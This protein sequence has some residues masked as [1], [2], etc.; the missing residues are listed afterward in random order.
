MSMDIEVVDSAFCQPAVGVAVTLLREVDTA[1]QEQAAVRTDEDGRTP[2]LGQYLHRG[3]YRLVLSFDQYFASLGVDSFQSCIDI[4]F[5]VFHAGE[6]V[7][8][9]LAVT[10]S[11]CAFHRLRPER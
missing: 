6:D 9:L 11:S 3:R 2:G 10:P 1:W 8:L 7:R 4:D 5:R